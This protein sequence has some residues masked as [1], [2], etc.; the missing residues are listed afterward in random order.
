MSTLA[1]VIFVLL[2]S[3]RV[4]LSAC[5]CLAPVLKFKP[6]GYHISGPDSERHHKRYEDRWCQVGA[7]ILR[8]TQ[9]SLAGDLSPFTVVDFGSNE[10]YFSL[11]VAS[12]FPAATVISVDSNENFFGLFPWESHKKHR[13]DLSAVNNLLCHSRY[14]VSTIDS[15]LSSGMRARFALLLSIFHW[16]PLNGRLEFETVL[17]KAVQTA[18]TTFIELPEWG[19]NT[20]VNWDV[21]KHWYGP[22]DMQLVL[23]DALRNCP[24]NPAVV[25]LGENKIDFGPDNPSTTTRKLYRI[26]LLTCKVQH[27]PCPPLLSA[28]R[29]NKTVSD[30][31]DAKLTGP[32]NLTY[33]LMHQFNISNTVLGQG[34]A[35]TVYAGTWMGVKHALKV[36]LNDTAN[37]L[38]TAYSRPVQLASGLK[39]LVNSNLTSPHLNIPVHLCRLPGSDK[40]IQVLPF[41]AG[42]PLSVSLRN[43]NPFNVTQSILI[44]LQ[45]G[46]ALAVLHDHNFVYFDLHA[47]QVLLSNSSTKLHVVLV[48]VDQVQLLQPTFTVCRCW[49]GD[50]FF[51]HVNPPESLQNCDRRRCT[52]KVDTYMFGVLLRALLP[53]PCLAS[54]CTSYRS[55]MKLCLEGDAK[56]RPTMR[57]VVKR[58]NHFTQLYFREA[59]KA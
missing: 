3:L 54:I 7:E 25:Y 29:C 4:E 36:S 38:L 13:G 48:D 26:D 5:G 34:H 28:L 35:S 49:P 59:P 43:Q 53:S 15:L 18:L 11:A 14:E 20:T 40:T 17:C 16:L 56:A 8:D 27:T 1:S 51:S 24:C 45:V 33:C 22:E 30:I 2:S 39:T 58:L 21:W 50:V 52:Q 6:F 55:L 47:G 19:K 41:V 42:T 10:G 9:Q 23:T 44:A 31:C 12:S 37:I 32:A 46:R 57:S